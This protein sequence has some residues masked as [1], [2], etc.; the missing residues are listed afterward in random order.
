MVE[1]VAFDK[2]GRLYVPK[3]LRERLQSSTVVISE[4]KEGL[5]IAPLD[6]D[7]IEA[8]SRLGTTQV[9]KKSIDQLRKHALDATYEHAT[10]KLR[11][12]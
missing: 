12:H 6:D 5:L 3:K 11:R 8:L 9:R 1:V 4:Q 7:P 10:K 2:Q